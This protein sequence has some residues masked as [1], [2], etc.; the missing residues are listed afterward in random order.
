MKNVLSIIGGIA[1]VLVAF[2]GLVYI[3][4]H[5]YSELKQ[6]LRD[7][8]ATLKEREETLEKIDGKV[9]EVLQSHLNDS[10]TNKIYNEILDKPEE[11]RSIYNSYTRN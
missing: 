6:E 3:P 7:T 4:T 10:L 8:Q 2:Y 1:L 11:T 9:L 5:A